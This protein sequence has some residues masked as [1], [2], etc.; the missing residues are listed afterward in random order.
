MPLAWFHSVMIPEAQ[1]RVN[2]FSLVPK[3]YQLRDIIRQ[4]IED[5]EWPAHSAIPSERDLEDLYHLSRTT[6]REALRLLELDGY[7]YRSHGRGTFVAPPK[8][9][10][11]LNA[12]TSFTDDMRMRGMKAGQRILRMGME[13]PSSYVREQLALDP[14]VERVFS[15]K[16]LRLADGEPIGLQTAYLALPPGAEITKGDLE[17]AGSLYAVLSSRFGLHVAEAEQT[18]EATLAR[19]DEAELLGIPPGSPLLLMERRALSQDRLPLEY[20]KMLHRGDRYRYFVRV[21]R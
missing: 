7:I 1:P 3:Y 20:T 13:E 17:K 14:S 11:A 10:T 9:L 2:P 8:Q 6:I 15:L 16:R 19:P 18:V 21:A 12:M 4:K 5:G